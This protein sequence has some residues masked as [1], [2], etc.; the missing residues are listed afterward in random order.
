MKLAMVAVEGGAPLKEFN[1]PA[2][3]ATA[4][5]LPRVIC[6]TRDGRD[7]TYAD[8]SGSAGNI[9]SQPVAGGPAR[10][11]TNFQSERVLWFDWSRDG[12]QLAVARGITVSDV[13]M[14]SRIK[15]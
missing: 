6:W 1:R 7:L 14:I 15:N 8:N 10:Q 5:Y 11:L 12:T 13:M 2:S 3:P 9:W 4:I